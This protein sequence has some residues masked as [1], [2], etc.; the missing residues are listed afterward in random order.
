MKW[1]EVVG[2]IINCIAL[3]V[4]FIAYDHR[5]DVGININFNNFGRF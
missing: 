5:Y 4:V 3:C 2:S 1:M